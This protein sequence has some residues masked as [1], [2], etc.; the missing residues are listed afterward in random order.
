MKKQSENT[1]YKL[2]LAAT[3]TCLKLI[4]LSFRLQPVR[5]TKRLSNFSIDCRTPSQS[6][7]FHN[8]RNMRELYY[9]NMRNIRQSLY[10]S[11]IN[12]KS[13]LYVLCTRIYRMQNVFGWPTNLQ[14]FHRLKCKFGMQFKNFLLRR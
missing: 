13:N 11:S 14:A 4:N 12:N 1:I 7:A 8:E 2:M 9:R 6:N 3:I 10:T 5:N